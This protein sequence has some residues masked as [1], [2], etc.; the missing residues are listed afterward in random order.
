MKTWKKIAMCTALA[1]D[2]F[3]DDG[4]ALVRFKLDK[5]RRK[6]D[7]DNTRRQ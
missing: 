5:E 7:I 6:G 4:D 1:A 2:V 3:D